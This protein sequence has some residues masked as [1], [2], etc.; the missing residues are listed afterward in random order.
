MP[1]TDLAAYRIRILYTDHHGWLYG[2]LR[3][4]FGNVCDVADLAHDTFYVLWV[5]GR[6]Q[7]I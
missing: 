5:H 6:Y 4:K 1:A 2:W 7:Y 3:R